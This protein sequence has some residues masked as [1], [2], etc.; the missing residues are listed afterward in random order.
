MK[1]VFIAIFLPFLLLGGMVLLLVTTAYG[2][3]IKPILFGGI[4][5]FLVGFPIAL[6]INERRNKIDFEKYTRE[7]GWVQNTTT[8]IANPFG[9]ANVNPYRVYS[10]YL[11]PDLP[12]TI[13]F[14]IRCQSDGS[15]PS[16]PACYS[17]IAMYFPI[18]VKLSD[19]WL[20]QWQQKIKHPTGL[21]PPVHTERTP[22]GGAVVAWFGAAVRKNVEDRIAEVVASL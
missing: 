5:I 15:C 4:F 22:D 13:M 11:R 8:P 2:D 21:F 9:F 10:G 1:R 16:T 14:G 19:A 7:K 12:A 6:V 18:G 17:Y 3:T 20:E